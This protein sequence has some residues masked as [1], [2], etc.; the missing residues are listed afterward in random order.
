MVQPAAEFAARRRQPDRAGRCQRRVHDLDAAGAAA[1]LPEAGGCAAGHVVVC[2]RRA[3]SRC[4]Q[5]VSPGSLKD[6]NAICAWEPC[7][8]SVSE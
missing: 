6:D 5:Q 2:R 1:A 7:R 3:A 4:C 8:G